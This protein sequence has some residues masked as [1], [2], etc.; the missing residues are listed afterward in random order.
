[1]KYFL[2]IFSIGLVYGTNYYISPKG[3]DQQAGTPQKP[4][5]TIDR[6]NSMCFAAGDG[7]YFQGS[8]TFP[9]RIRLNSS[10]EMHGTAAT[11]IRISSYGAGRATITGGFEVYDKGGIVL[12]NLNFRNTTAGYMEDGIAFHITRHDRIARRF[13]R[14]IDVDVS[15]FGGFG[16]TFGSWYL[17]SGGFVDIRLNRVN[18]YNNPK[19]GIVT[20]GPNG[21]ALYWHKNVY[22]GYS[23][24]YDNPGYKLANFPSGWRPQ[25]T[26]NGIL[27]GSVDGGTIEYSTAYNNG[28][29]NNYVDGPVG[30]MIFDSRNVL[31]QQ[32]TSYSNRTLD[33][34]GN[35]FSLDRNTSNSVMQN[36]WSWD[37]YG[38]GLYL[39]QNADQPYSF[40]NI[41]RY[42]SS[43]NDGR[44]GSYAGLSIWGPMRDIQ[45][46]GNQ[47]LMTANGSGKPKA[48][49]MSNY[50]LP[51]T[52][53]H[54]ILFQNNT[55]ETRGNVDLLHVE[56]SLLV[57][58]T[59]ILFK[60]NTYNAEYM[61]IL[62]G[63]TNFASV[64]DWK[65][66]SQMEP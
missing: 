27:L 65:A 14:V 33:R 35:G 50:Y 10:C 17:D 9:G 64:D 37:N 59:G 54:N 20:W 32:C 13:I 5:A 40:G 56:A 11:P 15:G 29:Q 55:F 48:V 58:S 49:A 66:S 47:V 46:Y 39:A 52:Y 51:G 28:S 41:V 18:S 42:N 43:Q 34:D 57:G 24:A 36:N 3:S 4:W 19:G 8:Q 25:G 12:Q 60:G 62:W 1:M 63:S 21:T 16:V 61:S 6:V 53:V 44:R 7:I 45:I 30:I 23:A 2:A 26:G 31:I 22:V 38:V